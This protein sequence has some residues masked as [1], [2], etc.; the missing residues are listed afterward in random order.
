MDN[1]SKNEQDTLRRLEKV[2]LGSVPEGRFCLDGTAKDGCMVLA[3]GGDRWH[4][5]F[6]EGILIEDVTVHDTLEEAALQLIKNVAPSPEAEE[7][8]RLAFL[9]RP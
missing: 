7:K 8:M 2:L 5:F 3:C 1:Y 4:V 6:R 9:G